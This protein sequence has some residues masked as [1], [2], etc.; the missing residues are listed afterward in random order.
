MG[1]ISFCERKQKLKKKT[2][3]QIFQ[4]PKKELVHVTRLTMTKKM[5][6]NNSYHTS[7]R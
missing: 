1:K 4:L 5:K 6:W 2:Q 3:K 7:A